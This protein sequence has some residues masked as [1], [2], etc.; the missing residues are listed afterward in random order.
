ME[1]H[2]CWGRFHPVCN[3]WGILT[4]IWLVSALT[5]DDCVSEIWDFYCATN[6]DD[7]Q[8]EENRRIEFAAFEALALYENM[9]SEWQLSPEWDGRKIPLP[10]ILIHFAA[11]GLTW[12]WT[13]TEVEWLHCSVNIKPVCLSLADTYASFLEQLRWLILK[14]DSVQS[15]SRLNVSSLPPLCVARDDWALS[16]LEIISPIRLSCST[17][18]HASQRG[19]IYHF[20]IR[21]IRLFLWE[22]YQ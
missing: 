1:R 4:C 12:K 22:C 14:A 9:R 15:V 16:V 10:N 7:A 13:C 5:G 18:Y 19:Q 3:G 8:Q 6:R 2:P 17:H 11:C 21:A 20:N